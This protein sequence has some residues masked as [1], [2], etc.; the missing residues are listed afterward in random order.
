MVET[1]TQRLCDSQNWDT[2]PPPIRSREGSSSCKVPGP[3]IYQELP[4]W[5]PVLSQGKAVTSVRKQSGLLT[6]ESPALV[7][8]LG[9]QPWWT[10][11]V[12]LSLVMCWWLPLCCPAD[13]TH[14]G[15]QGRARSYILMCWRLALGCRGVSS[16]P[17]FWITCLGS[18]NRETC[19][20]FTSGQS[21][22]RNSCSLQSVLAVSCMWLKLMAG[23]S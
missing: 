22:P 20:M 10:T 16:I 6:W 2:P 11:L 14:S 19:R 1:V 7:N 12:F 15:V 18:E 8:S 21:Q 13:S 4:Q 9:E 17:H 5:K 23:S 3:I